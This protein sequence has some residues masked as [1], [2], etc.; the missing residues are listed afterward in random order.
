MC[1]YKLGNFQW[2]AWI[3]AKELFYIWRIFLKKE[4]ENKDK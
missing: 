3:K 4:V 2:Q 1:R